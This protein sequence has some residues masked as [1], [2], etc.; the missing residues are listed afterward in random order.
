MYQKF[1]LVPKYMTLRLQS[2]ILHSNESMVYIVVAIHNLDMIFIS[3]HQHQLAYE[4]QT[5]VE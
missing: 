2:L 5:L 1:G 3:L 4:L